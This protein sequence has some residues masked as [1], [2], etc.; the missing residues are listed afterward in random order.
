[1]VNVTA[2]H[3]K[4]KIC[5]LHSQAV[6]RDVPHGKFQ[7]QFIQREGA[8]VNVPH[9]KINV[10]LMQ[11]IFRNGNGEQSTVGI[12]ESVVFGNMVG[13][14]C[15][16]GFFAGMGEV[17]GPEAIKLQGDVRSV[18]VNNKENST[19]IQLQR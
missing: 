10:H 14:L 9:G 4:I 16:P 8:K 2:A 1:M 19:I 17:P 5:I 12:R 13:K 3:G 18:W 7:I 11:D 6:G 15:G